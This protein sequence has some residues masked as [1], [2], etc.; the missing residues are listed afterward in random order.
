MEEAIKARNDD[1]LLALPMKIEADTTEILYGKTRRNTPQPI[2]IY[3]LLGKL[4][5]DGYASAKL[6]HHDLTPDGTHA[7]G[8][9]RVKINQTVPK[10]WIANKRRKRK[11]TDAEPP[12][13]TWKETAAHLHDLSMVPNE[14]V[15]WTWYAHLVTEPYPV[16]MLQSPALVWS[17]TIHFTE[18]QI[19]QFA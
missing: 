4:T 8:L 19:F 14:Y 10:C 1:K 7:G 6:N 15:M 9:H 3:G 5:L 16:V 2:T 11:A 12:P 18:G 17:R 13:A